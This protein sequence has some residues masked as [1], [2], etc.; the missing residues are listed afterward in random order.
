MSAAS[1]RRSQTLVSVSLS[2]FPQSCITLARMF[3]EPNPVKVEIL[4]L[5]ANSVTEEEKQGYYLFLYA[6]TYFK[7]RGDSFQVLSWSEAVSAFLLWFVCFG[8][9][10][11][12]FPPLTAKDCVC[13]C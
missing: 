12:L 8:L 7:V 3:L 4:T 9:V 10:F 5:L 11:F 1:D 2:S 6:I 13:S